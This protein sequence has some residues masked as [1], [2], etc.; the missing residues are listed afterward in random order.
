MK[1]VPAS[2]EQIVFASVTI[3]IVAL[4]VRLLSWHDTRREVGKI[5]TV[6]AADYQNAARVFRQEGVR[7]LFNSSGPLAD[8]NTLGHPPGYP[9]LIA[10]AWALFGESNSSIQLSQ[11]IC[12][13]LAAV[14]ILLIAT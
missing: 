2:F 1:D 6:V 12:D 10:I 9:V 4:G 13:A 14:L 11:I 8:P 3:F 7:A 5:Q